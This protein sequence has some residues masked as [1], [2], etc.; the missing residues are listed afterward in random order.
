MLAAGAVLLGFHV[1]GLLT[2]RRGL[3]SYLAL[4]FGSGSASL[5]SLLVVGF[6][7]VL[8]ILVWLVFSIVGL[9]ACHQGLASSG[10]SIILGV[11]V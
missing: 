8:G 3:A 11:V 6:G 2:R 7:V 9:L 1:V 5:A 4:W 10:F